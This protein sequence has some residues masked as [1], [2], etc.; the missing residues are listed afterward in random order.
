MEEE[1]FSKAE[2]ISRITGVSEHT[3]IGLIVMLWYYSDGVDIVDGKWM[4][5]VCFRNNIR[6]KDI[7][8]KIMEQF[9][10]REIILVM[11]V[12][13]YYIPGNSRRLAAYYKNKKNKMQN[14]KR[15]RN[16]PITSK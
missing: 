1:D 3:I 12:D 5:K 15:K 11:G 10:S 9:I 16:E 14:S 7:R 2:R 6:G 4:D 13:Q 8:N